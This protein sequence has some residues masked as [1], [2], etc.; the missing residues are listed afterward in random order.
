[1][2]RVSASQRARAASASCSDPSGYALAN[3]LTVRLV[4]TSAS[5]I[6]SR[7]PSSSTLRTPLSAW[8]VPSDAPY[9]TASDVSGVEPKIR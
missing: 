7:R 5:E 3:E 1:M 9:W 6:S 8:V 4:K 2:S